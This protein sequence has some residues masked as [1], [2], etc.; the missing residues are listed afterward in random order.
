MYYLE[1]DSDVIQLR[2]L[3]NNS[4]DEYSYINHY[5]NVLEIKR[6]LLLFSASTEEISNFIYIFQILTESFRW[7]VYIIQ[8]YF[9]I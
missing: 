2:S 4:N 7:K 6:K 3:S 9:F 5:D 8:I 1:Y